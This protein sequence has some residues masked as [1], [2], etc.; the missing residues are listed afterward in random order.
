[1]FNAEV[2]LPKVDL[3]LHRDGSELTVVLYAT[4]EGQDNAVSESST[5][6]NTSL[7]G[8]PSSKEE[9]L[10]WRWAF[11][12]RHWSLPPTSIDSVQP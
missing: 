5:V 4:F 3:H 11:G 9:I 8:Q 6:R 1:M 10:S 12:V 2:R 7:G